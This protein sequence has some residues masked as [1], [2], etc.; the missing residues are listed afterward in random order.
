VFAGPIVERLGLDRY[1][2]AVF[3]APLDEGTSKGDII[4]RAV[5]TSAAGLAA[6]S[7]LM[8]GDREHDVHGALENGLRAVGVRWGYAQPGELERA[9][10]TTVVEHPD[11]LVP[12]A[13]D[14]VRAAA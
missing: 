1:V 12:T 6:G 8:V 14:L 2:D 13:L 3:G 5:A 10:A 4:A 11:E 7:L 9:G